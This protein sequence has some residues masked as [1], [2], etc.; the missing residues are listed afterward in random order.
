MDLITDLPLSHGYDSVLVVVDHGL[1]KGVI[2]H[3]CNKT[4]SA[5]DI[6]KIFFQHI[7]LQFGLHNRVISDR[8]PQFT[9][10]FA[11]ELACLLEY[12]V[13]LSTA[14][15]PQT[16]S[17]SEQVNQELKTYLWI[18]TKDEPSKWSELLPMVEFSH[19]AATHSVTNTTP[20]SLMMGY[21][22]CAYPKIG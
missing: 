15:H 8:G 21:E 16:D 11:R 13:A 10:A 18:F 1:L 3:P 7:F 12:N 19:N 6:A 2:F 17:E 5:V 9:S 4:A 22:P 20:F 14:Y